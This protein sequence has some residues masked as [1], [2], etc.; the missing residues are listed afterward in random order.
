M[1]PRKQI[2]IFNKAVEK[3]KKIHHYYNIIIVIFR[4]LY[5]LSNYIISNFI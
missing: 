1:F 5:Y 2:A 4:T 3:T